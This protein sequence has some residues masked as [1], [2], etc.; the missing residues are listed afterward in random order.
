M[1]HVKYF[2]TEILKLDSLQ[3]RDYFLFDR[4]FKYEPHSI[5]GG[6]R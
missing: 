1:G 4:R 6:A 3:F 2:A 5:R